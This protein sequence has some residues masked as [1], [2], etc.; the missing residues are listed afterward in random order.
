MGAM[1]AAEGFSEVDGVLM[2][3]GFSSNQLG[4]SGRGFSF[5]HDE[6]LDMRFDPSTGESA[7]EV[8]ATAPRDDLAKA[9][10]QFGEEP[11]GR[12]IAD[13]IVAA[14]EREPLRTSGQLADLV[15]QAVG[16][17]RGHLHP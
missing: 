17:R 6:P 10:Y 9:L 13:A 3:L 5:G 7:A 16:G 14:R 1:A 11:Q 2:D 12:R 8:L 15:S 4:G